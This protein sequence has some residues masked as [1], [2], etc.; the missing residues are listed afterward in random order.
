MKKKR[1]WAGIRFLLIFVGIIL[2][3]GGAYLLRE[4]RN[5]DQETAARQ[6]AVLK[7]LGEEIPGYM[8]ASVETGAQEEGKSASSAEAEAQED[9]QSA[10]EAG[11]EDQ[12][13]GQS[14]TL[15]EAEAQEEGRSV[16]AVEAE[17]GENGQSAAK[18]G[19]ESITGAGDAA[20]L[21]NGWNFP[22]V[23]VD[24]VDCAGILEIPSIGCRT[25]VGAPWA[26]YDYMA[27]LMRITVK[28]D[29]W[30]IASENRDSLLGRLPEVS[31]GDRVYFT[32]VYG[33]RAVYQ[34][35]AV[36]SADEIPTGTEP[37]Q[38]KVQAQAP[39]LNLCCPQGKKWF[40]AECTE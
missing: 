1:G 18:A 24:G 3:A 38:Q 27:Y 12:E 28:N 17:A 21:Q 13:D 37:G 4:R 11:A 36:Y 30:A 23:S 6:E 22:V 9:G 15:A 26:A 19:L 8:A 20:F 39:V 35:S 16:A 31:E 34:V 29:V 2:M 7:K 33:N 25:A 14:V 5:Y 40:V 32:D 10:T